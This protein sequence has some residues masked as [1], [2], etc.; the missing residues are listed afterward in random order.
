MPV[1]ETKKSTATRVQKPRFDARKKLRSAYRL[2]TI[3]ILLVVLL[4]TAFIC[5]YLIKA[6][7][8]KGALATEPQSSLSPSALCQRLDDL[9]T[10]NLP[11][12]RTLVQLRNQAKFRFFRISGHPMVQIGKDGWLMW[13]DDAT[14]KSFKREDLF[15]RDELHQWQLVLDD[16]ALWA[17]RNHSEFA[18]IITP[19]KFTTYR[20]FAPQGLAHNSGKSRADQFVEYMSKHSKAKVIDLRPVLQ[21]GRESEKVFYTTD[22]HWNEYGAF[23][24]YSEIVK[25]LPRLCVVK[26]LTLKDF[27]IEHAQF[28]DGDIAASA[29]IAGVAPDVSPVLRPHFQQSFKIAKDS[30]LK[31]LR[32]KGSRS[33][34]RLTKMLITEQQSTSLPK[35]LVFHDS[36]TMWLEPY[37]SH[38]ARRA[39]YDWSD[40]IDIRLL[41]TE[42]PDVVLYEM[43][44]RF[45]TSP[46]PTV[47]EV[48]TVSSGQLYVCRN[49]AIDISPNNCTITGQ[50]VEART[51][52]PQLLLKGQFSGRRDKLVSVSIDQPVPTPVQVFWTTPDNKS[53]SDK[54]CATRHSVSSSFSSNFRIPSTAINLRVDPGTT[55]GRYRLRHLKITEIE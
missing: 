32:L 31:E 39:V 34:N 7:S 33:L 28:N 35:L 21:K 51:R 17:R 47:P 24:G 12:R 49:P 27:T 16:C 55:T 36:F 38:H 43:T 2:D 54:A 1:A 26:P 30:H 46:P 37:L 48:S 18:F 25:R 14:L 44:E 8:S 20:A 22:T 52:D 15:N 23:L 5:D 11:G 10:S 9:F 40:Q 3:L 4:Y 53:F 41:R 6:A 50:I 19:D 29:D 42:K 45:L 13:C